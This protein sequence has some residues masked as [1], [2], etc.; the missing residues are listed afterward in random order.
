[1]RWFEIA[2]CLFDDRIQGHHGKIKEVG[3]ARKTSEKNQEILMILEKIK[4][5]SG[6][7]L[8]FTS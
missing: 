1:M 7:F 2:E 3:A 8:V 4:E 5:K 6:E